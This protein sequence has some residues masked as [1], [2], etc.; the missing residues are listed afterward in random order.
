M[1][2]ILGCVRRA[3]NDF[4]M[5]EPGDRVAAGVSGGKDSLA[6]LYALS[7]YRRFSPRP[8]ELTAVTVTMGLEPFDLSPVRALCGDAH[9]TTA[10]VG[11]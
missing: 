6:M 3:D 2:R 8:F 10:R 5:I 11:Q 7:L 9:A 1:K 4:H